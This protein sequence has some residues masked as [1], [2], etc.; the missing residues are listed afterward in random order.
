MQH[1][2]PLLWVSVLMSSCL[3]CFSSSKGLETC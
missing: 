1:F 2:V 3:L